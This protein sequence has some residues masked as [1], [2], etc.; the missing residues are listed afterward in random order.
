MAATHHQS[1][2]ALAARQRLADRLRE[3]RL[4]AGLSGRD[5]AA[6]TGWQPS[7]VSRLETGK[8][9]PADADIRAWCAACEANELAPDLIAASRAAASMYMEWRRLQRA[10]LKNLQNSYVP[11]Y[12]RTK[13]FRVYSSTVVPGMLQTPDYALAMLRSVAAFHGGVDD[14]ES[15]VQ[16]RTERSEMVRN[17]GSRIVVVLEESVLRHV[18]G[19]AEIM[20]AAQL[21][22]LLSAM[23]APAV[24]LGIIPAGTLRQDLWTLETFTLLDAERVSVELLTAAVTVTAPSEIAQYRRA[25]AAMAEHAVY[26]APARELI[27][28]AIQ[29]LSQLP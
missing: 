26:G 25:F 23:S 8:T 11:A 9:P 2:A 5:V 18:L 17:S 1:S 16:A 4:D 7:K 27:A 24:S 22:A 6:R 21:G 28:G 13:E 12:A 14:V 19:G 20:G 3:L 29:S 10:G 15:A